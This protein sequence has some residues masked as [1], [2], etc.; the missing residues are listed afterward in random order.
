[1]EKKP[2]KSA[3]AYLTAEDKRLC[4]GHTK[5]VEVLKA[6]L[7]AWWPQHVPLGLSKELNRAADNAYKAA[8]KEATRFW[9][10]EEIREVRDKKR[11]WDGA[12]GSV[13]DFSSL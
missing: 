2:A 5:V 11:T 4:E 13:G 3:E 8:E 12:E 6:G 1:M 9:G 7:L 10:T